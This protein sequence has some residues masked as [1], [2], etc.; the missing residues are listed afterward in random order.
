MA[1]PTVLFLPS[2][3][4]TAVD[5][6]RG[7]ATYTFNPPMQFPNGAKYRVAM[8]SFS[9]TN[10]FV[11]VSSTLA[12]N[13]FYYTDDVADA[14]KYSVTIPDGSYNV[15]DLSNSINNGVI[16]NG[17]A[18]GLI[19]LTPDFATNKVI[20]AISVAGWQVY[21]KVGS[22]YVLLGATLNQ[23]V[24][25]GGLTTGPYVELL[26]GIAT[27]NAL[28]SMYVKTSLTSGASSF[29]GRPSEIVG[30]IIPT[31]SIGAVQN[32]EVTNLIWIDANSL[33]GATLSSITIQ[34]VDQNAASVNLSDPFSLTLLI[35][36]VTQ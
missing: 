8:H 12:N 9:Y 2:A 28:T 4:A 5:L 30:T 14:D 29:A 1:S 15:S 6:T 22:P 35:A 19:T 34:I 16:T 23:L 7:T 36:N 32:T 27:F 10:Y 11:N 26:P 18:D 17:H 24:P 3:S 25:A 13:T 31:A 33:P 20:V 21:F